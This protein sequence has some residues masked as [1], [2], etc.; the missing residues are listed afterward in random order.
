MREGI[1]SAERDYLPRALE[2]LD[3]IIGTA[4]LSQP[5]FML[6]VNIRATFTIF[7]T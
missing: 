6:L 4:C 7:Q 1:I 2:G 5:T 3:V